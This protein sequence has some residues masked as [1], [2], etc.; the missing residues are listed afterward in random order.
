MQG[1]ALIFFPAWIDGTLD[2]YALHA[3]LPAVDTKFVSQIWISQ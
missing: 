1:M 3:A 2:P